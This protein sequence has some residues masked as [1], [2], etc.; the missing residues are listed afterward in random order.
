MTRKVSAAELRPGD[1]VLVHLDAFRGQRRKLK[2]RWGSDLHTVVC[3]MADSI[4]AYLVKNMRTGKTKVLHRM[5]LLLWL[6]E[7]G[8][9][10][11]YNFAGI[12]NTLP[13]TI[14]GK[15][16]LREW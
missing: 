3:R 16:T 4:P 1:H 15:P 7:Y 13:G 2:N 8:E 9:P 11:R 5:R 12:S 10:A 6:A 14:L